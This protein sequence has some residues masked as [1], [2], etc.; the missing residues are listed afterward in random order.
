M[1]ALFNLNERVYVTKQNTIEGPYKIV[2]VST[3]ESEDRVSYT[4][5]V[6]TLTEKKWIAEAKLK[7]YNRGGK[8]SYP[9][10]N[11]YK[12]REINWKKRFFFTE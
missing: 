11:S 10:Q 3:I 6:E 12:S 4:Y 8:V 9:K 7:K 5:L 1:S 2:K